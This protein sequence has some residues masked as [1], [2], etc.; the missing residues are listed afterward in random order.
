MKYN[1]FYVQSA[2]FHSWKYNFL[3][4]WNILLISFNALCK[5]LLNC[6][7]E[8]PVNDTLRTIT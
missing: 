4:M 1:V 2:M 5:K 3:Q 7:L 6:K 8:E